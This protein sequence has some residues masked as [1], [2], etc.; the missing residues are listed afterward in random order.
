[1][2]LA[3]R[4]SIAR[5]LTM[6]QLAISGIFLFVA[7]GFMALLVLNGGGE[8]PPLPFLIICFFMFLV[9]FAFILG[10]PAIVYIALNKRKEKWAIA[11][12]VSL[13]LQIVCGAGILSLL[14]IITLVLLANDEAS[15]YLG[16]K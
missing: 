4:I 7:L 13:V 11:A 6:V 8:L 15:K 9:C 10:L 5:T 1:M 2:T 14:P 3:K 16:M 12:F